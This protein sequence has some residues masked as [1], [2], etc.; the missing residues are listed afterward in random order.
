MNC[1]E[2][3]MISQRTTET[4]WVDCAKCEFVKEIGLEPIPLSLLIEAQREHDSPD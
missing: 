1:T 4:V 2:I 3:I